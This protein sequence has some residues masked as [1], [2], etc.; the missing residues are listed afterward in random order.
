LNRRRRVGRT[1]ILSLTGNKWRWGG[2]ILRRKEVGKEFR[3]F[4][5]N[6]QVR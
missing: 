2:S 1:R 5:L 3:D 6:I 4:R